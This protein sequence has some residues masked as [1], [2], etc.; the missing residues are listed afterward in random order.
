VEITRIESLLE[1]NEKRYIIMG[2]N[3]RFIPGVTQ[4]EVAPIKYYAA[5]A[6]RGMNSPYLSL[7]TKAQA[8][9]I[10]SDS[11]SEIAASRTYASQEIFNR[12]VT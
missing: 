1:S 4:Y 9:T 10:A 5:L 7:E 3:S 11:L 12:G 6:L 8:R 2:N